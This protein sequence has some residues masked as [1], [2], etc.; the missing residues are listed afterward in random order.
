MGAHPAGTG[1]AVHW[2]ME[3]DAGAAASE[4]PAAHPLTSLDDGDIS[5]SGSLPSLPQDQNFST[6]AAGV[7]GILWREQQQAATTDR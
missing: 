6:R 1:E 7:A 3:H 5:A 4:G 2:L